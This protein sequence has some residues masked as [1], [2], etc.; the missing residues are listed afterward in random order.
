MPK[1][2][3]IILALLLVP[4]LI[5]D[6]AL[7]DNVPLIT[8]H[9]FAS[10]ALAAPVISISPRNQPP[11]N[12]AIAAFRLLALIVASAGPM[13]G[14]NSEHQHQ[15]TVNS[16]HYVILPILIFLALT[17]G[18]AL[19]MLYKRYR[20][21]ALYK[22]KM[23][24][25][26]AVAD[27]RERVAWRLYPETREIAA[28]YWFKTMRRRG[29]DVAA[30]RYI[31]AILPQPSENMSD[32]ER[33]MWANLHSWTEKWIAHIRTKVTLSQERG[34]PSERPAP[35]KS[36]QD[37]E[38]YMARLLNEWAPKEFEKQRKDAL[39]SLKSSPDAET[40]DERFAQAIESILRRE[41]AEPD[42]EKW[43]L[44]RHLT[45]EPILTPD[46]LYRRRKLTF[47]DL[48]EMSTLALSRATW[49]HPKD[50]EIFNDV[51]GYFLN[52]T[53]RLSSPVRGLLSQAA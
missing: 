29:Y 46:Q 8:Y 47:E 31:D 3:R 44:W 16:G 21:V 48:E 43:V 50:R 1:F 40:P 37:L 42:F 33:R 24:L 9:V 23:E 35:T 19:W 5:V 36:P 28:Y 39:V 10:Q 32:G 49:V 52:R 38:I 25:F 26:R 53:E 22:K 14:Q 6:P 13:L 11:H 4:S 7:A 20:E 17:F 41:L 45:Q 12:P 51:I 27:I 2:L 34:D 18:P 15:P 30:W